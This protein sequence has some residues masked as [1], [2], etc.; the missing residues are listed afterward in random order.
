MLK[1]LFMKNV[2]LSLLL[3]LVIM[4]VQCT[5]C[6]DEPET[7]GIIFFYIVDRFDIEL[8]AMQ[9]RRYESD[10]IQVLT[11]DNKLLD[12]DRWKVNGGG[13]ITIMYI[14]ADQVGSYDQKFTNQYLIRYPAIGTSVPVDIDTIKI[15]YERFRRSRKDCYSEGLRIFNV[16]YNGVL[17]HSALTESTIR[18]K[19]LK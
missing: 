3:F 2:L 18:L 16:Y 11:I 19:K 12:K 6:C 4:L 13:L 8:I 1:F 10:S 15:E 5:A 17:N 9:G 14:D 7:Q